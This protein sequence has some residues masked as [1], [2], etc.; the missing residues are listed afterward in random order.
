MDR[1]YLFRSLLY[2]SSFANALPQ[3]GATASSTSPAFPTMSA[4]DGFGVPEGGAGSTSTNE[5]VNG[6]A[7]SDSGAWTLGTGAI[8]GISVGI[9]V[10]V[11]AFATMWWLWYMAKKRQWKIRESIKRASR[12]MTGRKVPPRTPRVGP[13][14]PRS[15]RRTT[16]YVKPSAGPKKAQ[17]KEVDIEKGLKPTP[18]WLA[19]EK[20]RSRSRSPNDVAKEDVKNSGGIMAK[21]MFGNRR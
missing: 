16:M 11:I 15:Y 17:A 14:D 2:L 7:G 18:G 5:N 1:R 12:R 19:E 8:V 13:S 20:E 3:S 6:A 4:Q 10:V 21:F 9:A